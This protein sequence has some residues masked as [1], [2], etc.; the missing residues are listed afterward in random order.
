MAMLRTKRS[1]AAQGMVE[2]ALVLPILLLILLGIIA[3]GH[4]FFVYS[5]T[6]ASSREAARWGA[7]AGKTDSGL[8][9]CA[10]C[11]IEAQSS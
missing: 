11:R 7:A 1:Q 6:V 8:F 3:F 9:R 5:F 2:F 10:A 4:L